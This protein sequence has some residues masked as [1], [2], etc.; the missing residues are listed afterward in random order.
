MLL[1]NE[2]RCKERMVIFLRPEIPV[3]SSLKPSSQHLNEY[4]VARARSGCQ[5]IAL[6]LLVGTEADWLRWQVGWLTR[7]WFRRW[8]PGSRQYLPSQ[9]PPLA[10]W[11]VCL[12]VCLYVAAAGFV[13]AAWK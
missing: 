9:R 3:K 7:Q 1:G 2:A 13:E 11:A 5:I 6:F 4:G 10:A 12:L 8:G